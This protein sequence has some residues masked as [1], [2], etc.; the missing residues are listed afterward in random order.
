VADSAPVQTTW[1]LDSDMLEGAATCCDV[2]CVCE[3]V[4]AEVSTEE[5]EARLW[6]WM[7]SS[8]ARGQA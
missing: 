7:C 8:E 6:L 1:M 2:T 4:R 5:M 3:V